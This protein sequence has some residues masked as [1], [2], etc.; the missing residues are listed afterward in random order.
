MGKGDWRRPTAVDRET[1]RE[2]WARLCETDGH[3]FN[4]RRTCVRCL[5]SEY[6]VIHER[7]SE[8]CSIPF[9]RP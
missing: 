5:R 3:A 2:N 9:H 4:G 7:E 8:C 1:E 6:E